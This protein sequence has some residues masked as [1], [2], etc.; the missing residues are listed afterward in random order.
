MDVYHTAIRVSDLDAT[1]AF[2]EEGLGL[3]FDRE[4]TDDGVRNYYVAGDTEAGIQFRYEPDD[5]API[6]PAGIH[7]L[8]IRVD[9][10]EGAFERVVETAGCPVVEEPEPP[11]EDDSRTAFVEDPDGYVVELVELTG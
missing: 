9:D 11:G 3:E 5:D 7:H 2:Y 1:R 8:A 4:F 6:E 10:V